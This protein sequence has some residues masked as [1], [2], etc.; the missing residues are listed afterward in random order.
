MSSPRA[1]PDEVLA[2]VEVVAG[3]RPWEGIGDA[4]PDEVVEVVGAA[5]RRDGDGLLARLREEVGQRDLGVAGLGSTAE[6]LA[7]ARAAVLL[8]AE[9]A[10][11]L[12]VGPEPLLVAATP[13]RRR[14]LGVEEPTE[15]SA[16]DAAVRAALAGGA[17]VRAYEVR[18]PDGPSGTREPPDGGLGALLRWA[19]GGPPGT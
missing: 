6:A 1:S 7:A 5:V 4:I 17:A 13:A 8:V 19:D 10:G 2:I 16:A 15:V 9:P 14:E 11:S 3:E 12:W 18:D